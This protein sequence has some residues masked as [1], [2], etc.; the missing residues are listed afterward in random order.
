[1]R[2]SVPTPLSSGITS[3][4]RDLGIGR[5]IQQYEVLERWPSIVGERI[6]AVAVAERITDGR[7]FVRVS[8]SPWRNEL[9]F[10]KKELIDR[11]ND[12]MHGEFVRD[13]IFH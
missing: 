1:M 13:I 5:R 6:A 8:R 4:L 9:V 7:L 12:A 3:V 11:I 2:H 10:L